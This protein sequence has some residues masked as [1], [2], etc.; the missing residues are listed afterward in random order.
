MKGIDDSRTTIDP[1]SEINQFGEPLDDP[2]VLEVVQEY[3]NEL[4]QGRAPSRERFLARYPELAT[5][6]R[7][8][9]DGL[10]MVRGGLSGSQSR[11]FPSLTAPGPRSP[12]APPRALGDFLIVREIARGGMGVVYEA[13]QQSLGRR[14]ALK[15]LPFAA[16]F[17]AR[18]LQRFKNEA[19]A[20]ALLHHTNI[21]P[22][23]AVGCDRGVHFYA[24]QLIEGQ[25]LAVVIRQL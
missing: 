18:Q 25:S 7:D 8:C 3:L 4:E 23:Y 19:Q 16:T 1:A 21:V 11:S 14:V 6:V 13:V 20:A 12:E 10:E 2:R 9:L 5:A 17:D 15:V 24:M 22:I